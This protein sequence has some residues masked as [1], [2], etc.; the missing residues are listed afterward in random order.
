MKALVCKNEPVETGYRV[1][2]V[3]SDENI[4]PVAEDLE[5]ITCPDEVTDHYWYDPQT[6]QFIAPVI[7][8]ALLQ[9]TV[10]GAQNL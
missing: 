2:Q 10:E 9:P 4:F 6:Q 3:E 1:A 7:P 5:W 8:D